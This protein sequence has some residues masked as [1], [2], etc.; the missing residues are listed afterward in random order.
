VTAAAT[1]VIPVAADVER[2]ARRT[3]SPSSSTV[4][5]PP[6]TPRRRRRHRWFRRWCSSSS[7]AQLSLNRRI[8]WV[9]GCGVLFWPARDMLT[10]RPARSP[11]SD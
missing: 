10:R 3:L 4:K 2:A 7:A 8:E 9:D 11:V 1:I 5:P 6:P